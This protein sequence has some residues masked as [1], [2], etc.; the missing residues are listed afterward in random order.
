MGLKLVQMVAKSEMWLYLDNERTPIRFI[1]SIA[2]LQKGRLTYSLKVQ[3]SL[4]I[5]CQVRAGEKDL[6]SGQ[7]RLS[8]DTIGEVIQVESR[9]YPNEF[10]DSIVIS[11]VFKKHGNW[12]WHLPQLNGFYQYGEEL[13]HRELPVF[14]KEIGDFVYLDKPRTILNLSNSTY[15]FEK[16]E[17]EDEISVWKFMNSSS[18]WFYGRFDKLDDNKNVS[19]KAY[20]YDFDLNHGVVIDSVFKFPIYDKSENWKQ[21]IK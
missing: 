9:K 19:Y 4:T 7:Y 3:D 10:K 12:I 1:D 6:G 13:D 17:T 5:L 21:M 20:R 15:V 16:S 2:D 8:R 11:H 18:T 14:I